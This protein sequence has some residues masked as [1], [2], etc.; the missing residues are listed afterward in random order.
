MC[1]LPG[2]AIQQFI[3]LFQKDDQELRI[4]H[5]RYRC[6]PCRLEL[7][8][9]SGQIADIRFRPVI[10][11]TEEHLIQLLNN[12]IQALHLLAIKHHILSMK[13]FHNGIKL[14][15]N[16]SHRF[17]AGNI[18]AAFEGVNCSEHGL[19]HLTGKVD[20]LQA[21]PQI[22]NMLCGFGGKNQQ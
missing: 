22:D 13:L 5:W 12:V 2:V 4:D 7:T 18:G 20:F 21:L 1:Q 6:A 10:S 9:R 8:D 14:G 16:Q 11:D 3:G 17:D 15:S 19:G